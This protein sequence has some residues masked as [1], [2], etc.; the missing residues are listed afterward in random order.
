MLLTYAVNAPQTWPIQ[1][2]ID[3]KNMPTCFVVFQL[4]VLIFKLISVDALSTCAIVCSEVTTLAHEAWNDAMECAAFV[5]KSF[6]TGAQCSEV[7]YSCTETNFND[8]IAKQDTHIKH[9]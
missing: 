3:Y 8:M 9:S 5:S 1:D 4:E 7:L 6:L 2:A